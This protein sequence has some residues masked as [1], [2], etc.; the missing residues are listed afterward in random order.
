MK[1][2]GGILGKVDMEIFDWKYKK[3]ARKMNN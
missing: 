3:I 2:V 1:L